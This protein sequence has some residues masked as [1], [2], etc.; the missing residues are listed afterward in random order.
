MKK[1]EL[2]FLD[3]VFED[4][5]TSP[6]HLSSKD[7]WLAQFSYSMF[8]AFKT[9]IHHVDSQ[10]EE[11]RITPKG[12]WLSFMKDYY[13]KSNFAENMLIR[14][15]SGSHLDESEKTVL[16]DNLIW[17]VRMARR[18]FKPLE[19]TQLPYSADSIMAGRFYL[20]VF[21]YVKYIEKKLYELFN[22]EDEL[23]LVSQ[24]VSK[25]EAE[26]F[27]LDLIN[28]QI[29]FHKN[30]LSQL[31]TQTQIQV[32]AMWHRTVDFVH[33][34]LVEEEKVITGEK[35]YTSSYVFSQTT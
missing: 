30:D 31:D 33:E 13:D 19:G 21:L 2:V 32:A 27:E 17:V 9:F 25:I 20:S 18:V 34:H 1:E 24:I 28:D 11:N 6:E 35:E 26:Q 12:Q 3:S 15:A 14:L 23:S 4:I 22:C 7:F 8:N 5:D 29:Q 10:P 16:K